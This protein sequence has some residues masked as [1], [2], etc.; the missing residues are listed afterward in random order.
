MMWARGAPAGTV[1]AF[2]RQL[3]T[4]VKPVT[5]ATARTS[6]VPHDSRRQAEVGLIYGL[7]AYGWWGLIPI[8]FKLVKHLPPLLVLA[9]R[10]AW[11]CAFFAIL[12]AL[13]AR[14]RDVGRTLRARNTILLLAA[15]TVMLAANWGLFI[16]A[17]STGR[18]LQAS[19]GYFIL[20]LV[21]V[22]LAVLILRERLRRGQL[23]G[24]LFAVAGVVV[25]TIA[26][27][28]S[29]PWIALA[30]AFS[31]GGYALMRKIAHVDPL[32]GLLVETLILTP[33]AIAYIVVTP[34]FTVAGDAAGDAAREITRGDYA[35]LA[36]SGAVTGIPLLWFTAAAKRLRLSTLGFLQY[37]TPTGQLLL[38]IFVYGETFGAANFAGFALIWLA[39][40][41]YS[42]DSLR[43]HREAR[44]TGERGERRDPANAAAL[45]DG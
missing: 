2:A 20:P 45:L 40:V 12:V 21:T 3:R 31:W 43:A 28:G 42:A 25:L 22:S 11:S 6:P 7:A 14:W 26:R 19:L 10:V 29:A 41:V 8:Y 17:V 37:L 1:V 13:L 4:V 15:S 44:T 39:L 18:V 24:L 33:V 23:T 30:I 36:L 35:L 9:H 16:F 5:S 32:E 27:G 38:A 34:A